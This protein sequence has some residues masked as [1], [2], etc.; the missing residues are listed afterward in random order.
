[1]LHTINKSPFD[2]NSLD[3]CLRLAAKGGAILFIEDAVYA[4]LRG[5]A[6]AERIAGRMDDLS[7]YVLGPDLAARGLGESPLIDGMEV[8]DY[9]GFVN[10]VAEHDVTQAWL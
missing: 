10:L 9:G 7:F 1:M 3:S 8:V 4:A 2:R 5:T 6:I